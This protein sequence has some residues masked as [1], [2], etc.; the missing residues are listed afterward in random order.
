MG[1]SPKAGAKEAGPE[2]I[3]KRIARSG[4][5][6][7]RDAERLI[8]EGRVAVDGAS[9]ASPALNVT[10]QNLV[11]VDGQ[12][13]SAPAP[14]RL[15]RHHKRRGLITS[16][17]DPEG[18]ATLFEHLPKEL[19]RVIAVGRLDVNSEGLLLLTNDGAL[20][21]R[22]ELPETGW[23]RR[24]RVR[25]HGRPE[26]EALARLEQGITI[27]GTAYGPIRARIDR[28]QGSNCW[29]TLALSEGKR[30]EVRRV[31]EHL[32][33]PVTRLIRTSFGPFQLGRLKPGALA[34]VPQK[35]IREQLGEG[36]GPK[37]RRS[38]ARR[39]R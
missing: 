35:V 26:P 7:R 28:V 20:A 16:H 11:T 29:L 30:R 8:A 19:G 1:A 36:T 31:L 37:K 9:I 12:A 14:T 32:G 22:L 2:R 5:C 25:V 23:V 21:R 34:E 10:E 39:R 27:G 6:S 38:D 17:R 15:W 33:C 4:L 13:L 24:Y 18:R 3:A